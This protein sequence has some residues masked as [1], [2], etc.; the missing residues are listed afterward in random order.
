MYKLSGILLILKKIYISWN[1]KKIINFGGIPNSRDVFL[2]KFAEMCCEAKR[3]KSITDLALF[4]RFLKFPFPQ[5][6]PQSV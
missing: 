3:W 4:P 5:S 1:F 2:N 6:I